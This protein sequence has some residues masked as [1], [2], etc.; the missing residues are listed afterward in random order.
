MRKILIALGSTGGHIF[1]AISLLEAIEEKSIESEIRLVTNYEN[2]IEIPTLKNNN[3]V[4]AI[5]SIGFIGKSLLLKAKSLAFLIFSIMQSTKIIK[6][7]KPEIIVGTGGFVFL[8]V[9]L[10]GFILKKKIYIIEGNSVPGLSNRIISKF[11]TKIFI[12][13]NESKNYFKQR[14]CINTGFPIRK[15]NIRELGNKKVDI[16]ILGGSQGSAFLNNKFMNVI[17]PLLNKIIA[18]NSKEKKF[19]IIHQCGPNNKIKLEEFYKKTK[20]RFPFFNF[21]VSEFIRNIDDH[22]QESKILI[23]RA[24][25][26]T[27]SESIYFKIPAVFVPI[28]KSSGNHQYLNAKE[29]CKENLSLMSSENESVETLL[30]KIYNLLYNENERNKILTALERKNSLSRQTAAQKIAWGI[31]NDVE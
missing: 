4:Y 28:E 23:S 20:E 22:F 31:L 15:K 1:P 6:N 12:N 7:Y 24:G 25:A 29:I 3:K 30:N 27:I 14:K 21:T 26:S 19:R 16:L 18:S 2:K 9:A 11:C 8:P 5:N 17:V 10:A 13:F